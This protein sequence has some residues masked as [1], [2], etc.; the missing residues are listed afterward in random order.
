MLGIFLA[1]ALWWTYFDVVALIS[2][3]RLGEAEVGR[4]QNELAR[5]SYSYIHLLMV[6]GHRPH[7][8]RHEG[9]DRP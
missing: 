5:D 3:R 8:L 9:D 2:A 4:V 7:R 1:A 6:A